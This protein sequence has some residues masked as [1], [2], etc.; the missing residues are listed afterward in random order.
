MP[1]LGLAPECLDLLRHKRKNLTFGAGPHAC[2]G[3][4]LAIVMVIMPRAR[5]PRLMASPP[6]YAACDHYSSLSAPFRLPLRAACIRKRCG[7]GEERADCQKCRLRDYPI[8]RRQLRCRRS[9]L[10]FFRRSLQ[11]LHLLHH[12]HNPLPHRVAAHVALLQH[13]V[14]ALGGFEDGVFA[15]LVGGGV[16]LTG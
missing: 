3:E 10:Q 7:L 5:Y 14:G 12:P 6:S 15:A 1:G 9:L 2:P 11:P 16:R 8:T 13:R 4:G